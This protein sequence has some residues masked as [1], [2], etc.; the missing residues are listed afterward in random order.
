MT[1]PGKG[2]GEIVPFVPEP[3]KEV[4][5]HGEIRILSVWVKIYQ[6]RMVRNNIEMP[7]GTKGKV[8]KWLR[9]GGRQCP[10]KIPFGREGE[11]PLSLAVEDA[12][13]EGALPGGGE[14]TKEAK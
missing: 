3:C 2:N 12:S 13:G 7:A 9:W 11:F 8:A 4:A 5:P 6:I 14:R 1:A 10:E